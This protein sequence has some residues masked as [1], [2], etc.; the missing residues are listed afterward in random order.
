MQNLKCYLLGLLDEDQGAW[1]HISCHDTSGTENI[2]AVEQTRYRDGVA[3]VAVPAAYDEV[4]DGV[5]VED[6][7]HAAVDVAAVGTDCWEL[8]ME[9][10][11]SLAAE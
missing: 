10:F 5:D 6:D 9:I 7:A 3:A 1:K 4:D 11:E 2:V 8:Q